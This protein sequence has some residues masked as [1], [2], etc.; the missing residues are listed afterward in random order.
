MIYIKGNKNEGGI[1][2]M[3]PDNDYSEGSYT[4]DEINYE[5]RRERNA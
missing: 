2:N 1:C 4:E 5:E 3:E